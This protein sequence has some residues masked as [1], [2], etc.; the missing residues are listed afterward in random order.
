ML[1]TTGTPVTVSATV[2]PVIV[3]APGWRTETCSVP[4]AAAV[5]VAT[6]PVGDL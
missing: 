4:M 6:R 2:L 3:P 1:T 5:L